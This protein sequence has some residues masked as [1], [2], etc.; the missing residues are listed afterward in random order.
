MEVLITACGSKKESK[1]CTAGRLYKS[2]RVRFLH[3]KAKELNLPFYIL[4]AKYGLISGEE[5]IE[6]YDKVMTDKA[7]RELEN[8]IKAVLSKYDTII[9]YKGGAR[10]EYYNCI[11]RI[12]DSLGKRFISFGYANMGD[13]GK[14]KSILEEL[15]GNAQHK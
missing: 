6:P 3:R 15:R 1:P 12:A 4:S 2:S 13:I 11:K 10:R 5:V 8:Q 7:C 14:L 9:F